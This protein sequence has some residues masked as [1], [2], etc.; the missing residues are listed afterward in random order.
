M[1]AWEPAFKDIQNRQVS[2]S[3]EEN[4]EKRKKFKQSTYKVAKCKFVH[5]RESV[6]RKARGTVGVWA[7]ERDEQKKQGREMRSSTL[8][9][10][11]WLGGWVVVVYVCVWRVGGGW[12]LKRDLPSKPL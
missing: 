10:R 1:N 2:N 9:V 4:R 5:V 6:K 12:V 7:A 11:I 3:D 8:P